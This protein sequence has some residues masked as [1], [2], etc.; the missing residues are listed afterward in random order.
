MP[1]QQL[2]VVHK[3]MEL[4]EELTAI[5]LTDKT[6]ISTRPYL[7]CSYIIYKQYTVAWM[8]G[9]P[10]KSVRKKKWHSTVELQ[11]RFPSGNHAPVVSR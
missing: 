7:R 6:S 10:L 5:Q 3:E 11:N 8:R 1:I 9:P 4:K 2:T